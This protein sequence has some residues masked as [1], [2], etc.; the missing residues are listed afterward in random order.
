[1]PPEECECFLTI[2]PADEL[3]YVPVL[4]DY[5]T[6]QAWVDD[7]VA[8][9]VV[10]A[11]P[12]RQGE[13]YPIQQNVDLITAD[14]SV[15][16]QITINEEVSRITLNPGCLVYFNVSLKAGCVLS[17]SWDV[18]S[19]GTPGFYNVQAQLRDCLGEPVIDEVNSTSTSGSGAFD[20]VAEDG[21][22]IVV[23]GAGNNTAD[24]IALE[25]VFTAD[26][27]AVFNPVIAL[28]DDSGTTRQLE[29]CARM[30][31]PPLT[32]STGDWYADST[33]ADAAISDQ[34]DSCVGYIDTA[35]TSFTATDGGSSLTLAA[36]GDT[37]AQ[38]ET[39]G[40]V[41]AEVGETLSAAWTSSVTGGGTANLSEFSI[42]DYDG[43]LVESVLPFSSP[44]TSAALPY[45]GRYIVKVVTGQSGATPPFAITTSVA[46]TSSGALTVN[47]IQALYDVGLTCPA[48][49]D[50]E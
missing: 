7:F 12:N 6:A 16:D 33:E 15:P 9:C 41:N 18:T 27:T 2:P 46:I 10:Y 49:L 43:V 21:K 34:T 45:T 39:W 23:I 4:P 14:L 26:D 44:A 1:V 22:Y 42:Y 29:A 50:C 13:S 30:L 20:A 3:L 28:W 37:D 47:P 36:V 8:S 35:F 31:L 5:A 40:S 38:V 32:E 24:A 19:D 25:A 48:R 11:T 17:F